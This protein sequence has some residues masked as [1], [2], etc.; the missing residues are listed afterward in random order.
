VKINI[1]CT[2]I[3]VIERGVL[4]IEC[5]KCNEVFK[6]LPSAYIPDDYNCPNCKSKIQIKFVAV[7]KEGK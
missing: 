5:L 1:E 3:N 7:L 6:A 2:D 4:E